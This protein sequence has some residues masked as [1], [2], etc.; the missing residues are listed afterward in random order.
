MLAGLLKSDEQ[1]A[2]EAR[3]DMDEAEALG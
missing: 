3:G 1:Q 2:A